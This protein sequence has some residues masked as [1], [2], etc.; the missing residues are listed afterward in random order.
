MHNNIYD[1]EE[2]EPG[3]EHYVS[4]IS[5]RFDFEVIREDDVIFKEKDGVRTEIVNGD[6]TPRNTLWFRAWLK[7][8]E[9]Y[10]E[11]W[12]YGKSYKE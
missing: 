1:H 11:E 7:L 8:I 10:G 6:D 3:Y 12:A 5:Y 4:E 2:S 9:E